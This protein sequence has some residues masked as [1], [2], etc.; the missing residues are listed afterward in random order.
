MRDLFASCG[1]LPAACQS[2]C[3]LV[4]E[5]LVGLKCTRDGSVLASVARMCCQY[6]TVF[7]FT[8]FFI[9]CFG[10]GFSSNDSGWGRWYSRQMSLIC[11]NQDLGGAG[12]TLHVCAEDPFLDGR[13]SERVT[14]A[15]GAGLQTLGGTLLGNK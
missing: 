1:L 10:G 11:K 15:S 9:L 2:G 7:S 4:R 13:S 12:H 5:C 8:S 14:S 3:A 6:S